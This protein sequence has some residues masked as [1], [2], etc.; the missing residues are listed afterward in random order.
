MCLGS[1]KVGNHCST[2][3]L[4]RT[5]YSR[6]HND[7]R[8]SQDDCSG[9]SDSDFAHDAS[10]APRDSAPGVPSQSP[11]QGSSAAPGAGSVDEQCS[12]T[13]PPKRPISFHHTCSFPGTP[14]C[15]SCALHKCKQCSSAVHRAVHHH[16]KYMGSVEVTRSMRTLDFDTRKQVTRE[17]INRLC[18]RTAARSTDKATSPEHKHVSCVLGRSNLQFAGRRVILSV[19][20][21]TLTLLA[22][23][24]QRITQHS[25]QAISFASG[26]DP[27]MEDYIAYVAKDQVNQRACHILECL[28]GRAAEV[29]RSIG[30]AFESRFKQLLCHVP[31]LISAD[32]RSAGRICNKWLSEE[33]LMEPKDADEDNIDGN[34]EHHHYYNVS[35][36]NTPPLGQGVDLWVTRAENEQIASSPAVALCENCSIKQD[37]DARTTEP[38]ESET[39][40][41]RCSAPCETNIGNPIQEEGWFHGRL[42][43]ERAESL[44]SCNGDF[45]V[46]ESSSARGQYVLSGMDGTAVRHLLLV[47][48]HGQVRTC[49]QVFLSVG[50][51]VRFHMHHRI[52]IVTGSNR[53]CL[54]QPILQRH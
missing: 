22:A 53:L 38:A 50:H 32:P 47:D 39:R 37:P 48:P 36:G 7:S 28:Q 45:L 27:D 30:W 46:R 5:K 16:I 33:T 18:K 9:H 41:K 19:S 12:G 42:G 14:S 13:K 20:A 11:P 17:A 29:I 43:R 2:G 10:S 6:L 8:S 26:G 35:P 4:K 31:S 24:S 51:L 23:S 49:D 54:Q 40:S 34:S 3:M 21:D 15:S 1:I 52:P 44:L 25:I